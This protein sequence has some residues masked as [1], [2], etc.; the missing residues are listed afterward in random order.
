MNIYQVTEQLQLAIDN[1]DM[2]SEFI[3]EKVFNDT[4]E[5]L[6]GELELRHKDIAAMI[7][8]LE[9]DSD[10]MAAALDTLKLRKF[11]VDAK[12][13]FLK[14]Y[15]LSSMVK[16]G[17]K[18]SKYPEFDIMVREH[19]RVVVSDLNAIPEQ[20]IRRKETVEADKSLLRE[21]LKENELQ[22][23]TLEK[24]QSVQVK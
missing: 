4:M 5:G 17:I 10:G 11:K 22:G 19:N 18:K 21:Y 6:R 20:F 1:L 13:D 3:D 9:S 2:N 8:N 16:N 15:I 12:A 23:A 14:K 7:K 24:F